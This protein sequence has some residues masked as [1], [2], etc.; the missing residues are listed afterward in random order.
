MEKLTI[1]QLREPGTQLPTLP[2]GTIVSTT[3]HDDGKYKT[4]T[5]YLSHMI[6]FGS[7]MRHGR[8]CII[9]GRDYYTGVFFYEVPVDEFRRL[10]LLFE[11]EIPPGRFDADVYIHLLHQNKIIKPPLGLMP[12]WIVA[13]QRCDEIVQAMSRYKAVKKEVPHEWIEEYV[14]LITY[15]HD[16][17]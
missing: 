2:A 3:K 5:G 14:D 15:L 8:E 16:R 6:S 13:E 9:V 11:E 17:K 1:D 12:R 4:A 10:G 7:T